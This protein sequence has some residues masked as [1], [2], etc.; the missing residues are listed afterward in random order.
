MAA[1]LGQQ[2][3]HTLP[4]SEEPLH[5]FSEHLQ[6]GKGNAG[7]L[8]KLSGLLACMCVVTRPAIQVSWDLI[9]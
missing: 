7:I 8:V 5:F 3:G 6:H 2:L 1:D 4:I 9:A